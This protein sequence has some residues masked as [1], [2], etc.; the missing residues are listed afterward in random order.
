MRGQPNSPSN[1]LAVAEAVAALRSLNV[2]EMVE[3][4]S[5]AAMTA[6]PLIR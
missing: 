4:S 5:A 3:R 6:F 1:V 2:H